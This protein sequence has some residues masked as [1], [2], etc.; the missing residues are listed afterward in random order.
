MSQ[1]HLYFEF[2]R[3]FLKSQDNLK[4]CSLD[5]FNVSGVVYSRMQRNLENYVESTLY[6]SRRIS[7]QRSILEIQNK[8]YS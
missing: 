5:I 3:I 7:S 4:Y 1:L 6:F 8:R 2:L